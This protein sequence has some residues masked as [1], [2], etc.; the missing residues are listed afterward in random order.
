MLGVILIC[1]YRQKDRIIGLLMPEDPEQKQYKLTPSQDSS[2]QNDSLA[3]K[4]KD[5]AES[6]G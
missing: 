3:D 2:H 5:F 6:A 1:L 4:V